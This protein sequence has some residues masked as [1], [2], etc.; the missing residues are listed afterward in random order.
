VAVHDGTLLFGSGF[1]VG[2]GNGLV[3]GYLMYR[4]GLVPRRMPRVG[5]IGD[6]RQTR[7]DEGR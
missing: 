5:L 3:L 1:C 7:G 6:P 2:F 4:S